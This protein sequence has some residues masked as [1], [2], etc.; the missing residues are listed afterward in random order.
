MQVDRLR[1]REFI[2]LLGGAAL[3]WPSDARA[4]L[5][6]TG[7]LI[8][9]LSPLSAAAATRNIAAFR[10]ALRDLG[11]VQGRGATFELSYADGLQERIAPLARDLVALKPDVLMVGSTSAVAAVNTATRAI[12]IVGILGE[13]PLAAGLANSISRPGG[14]VTG[15]WLFGEDGLFGKRLEFLKLAVPGLARVGVMLNL[16][17]RGDAAAAAEL[18]TAAKALN[19]TVQ[20]FEARD[21]AQISR[22]GDQIASSGVEALLVG[23]G[24]TLNSRR[25]EIAAMASRLRLPASYGFRESAEAGGLMSYGPSLPDVYRQSARLVARI[26]KG[27]SPANLPIEI[28]SRYELIVNLKAAK[29]IGLALPDSFVLLADELIE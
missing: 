23:S 13:S 5:S 4:Q 27:E 1:R 17:D 25:I 16:D 18:P 8:G 19:V 20:V 22:M 15:T 28:P 10:S 9:V 21:S 3:A 7:P 12:P 6:A 2:S 29:A 11:Y 24:S 26:L 14:N